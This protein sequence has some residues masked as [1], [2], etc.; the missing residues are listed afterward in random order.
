MSQPS[1][2]A[3]SGPANESDAGAETGA[4]AAV[5]FQGFLDPV[6]GATVCGWA[7]PLGADGRLEIEI[8]IDDQP[9]A[10]VTAE[11]FRRGLKQRGL[12]DGCYGFEWKI[13][14]RWADDRSHMVSAKPAGSQLPLG[15]S[16]RT[17]LIAAAAVAPEAPVRAEPTSQ[18]GRSRWPTGSYSADALDFARRVYNGD[19]VDWSASKALIEEIL[20]ESSLESVRSAAADFAAALIAR[21]M[22]APVPSRPMM[23]VLESEAL[24]SDGLRHTIVQ[25]ALQDGAAVPCV[26]TDAP[27]EV[28][29][30]AVGALGIQTTPRGNWSA[31]VEGLV[32]FA[33]PGDSFHPEFS[34]LMGSVS[35]RFRGL[36]WD[37]ALQAPGQMTGQTVLERPVAFPPAVLTGGYGPAILCVQAEALD[38]SPPRGL[39]VGSFAQARVA[40]RPDANWLYLPEPLSSTRSPERLQDAAREWGVPD[41]AVRQRLGEITGLYESL[42]GSPGF[43]APVGKAA[44]IAV[45]YAGDAAERGSDLLS[46]LATQEISG[47]VAVVAAIA[48]AGQKAIGKLQAHADQVLPPDCFAMI[49]CPIGLTPAA[50]LNFAAQRT[51]ADVL[52][53]VNAAARPSSPLALEV[54]ASWCLLSEIGVAASGGAKADGDAAPARLRGLAH[55]DGLDCMAI[56]H[57]AWLT[58][59]E[60]EESVFPNLFPLEW[61]VR[62]ERLGFVSLFAPGLLARPSYASQ[63]D[64]RLESTLLRAIHPPRMSDM[65]TNFAYA[66]SAALADQRTAL[67]VDRLLSARR[68]SR[69]DRNELAV[70]VSAIST[71]A[72]D[73]RQAVTVLGLKLDRIV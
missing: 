1:S 11:K 57:S 41:V 48:G 54:L 71:L 46:Q 6:Q 24:D 45:I 33:R 13:G 14:D 25:W 8:R 29:E 49:E 28:R 42:G 19:A 69:R 12:G 68:A 63:T 4:A 44:R 2:L 37:L 21:R 36:T 59:G 38:D 10:T 27:G 66:R 43:V 9:V 22:A 61:A 67:L 60:F 64:H 30:I 51:S 70:E 7:R 32:A 35:T 55:S 65:E 34:R 20:R 26:L 47:E 58:V 15:N 31:P 52:I 50:R 3:T 56:S 39:S 72:E 53:F 62:A 23:L 16:P 17:F 5:G 40:S 18:P 73:L